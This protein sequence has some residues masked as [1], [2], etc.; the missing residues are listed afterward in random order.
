MRPALAPKFKLWIS[1]GQNEGVFGDGKFR[2]LR[3]IEACGSLRGAADKLGISYRKAWGD[4]KKAERILAVQLIEKKRGGLSG[5]ST[6][7]TES[8]QRWVRAFSRFRTSIENHTNEE[9]KILLDEV[10]LQGHLGG[11]EITPVKKK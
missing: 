11:K 2:L 8:G 4:L 3:A 5:G 1:T 9:F 6:V 7:L 10:L